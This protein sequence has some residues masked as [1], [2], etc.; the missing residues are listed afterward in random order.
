M[1]R[2]SQ[3]ILQNFRFFS[4]FFFPPISCRW[5]R[6]VASDSAILES[7]LKDC[8]GSQKE[9]DEIS[10]GITVYRVF[11]QRAHCAKKKAFAARKWKN[12]CISFFLSFSLISH[13]HLHRVH[14]RTIEI[15]TTFFLGSFF[16]WFS[17]NFNESYPVST[18]TKGRR[19]YPMCRCN[20]REI[21]SGYAFNC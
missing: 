19:N 17:L 14:I 15:A 13:S 7:D 21:L 1:G 16:S 10:S 18:C 20:A 2:L 3:R 5:E 8:A 11:L 12:S 4:L 6:N 9:L